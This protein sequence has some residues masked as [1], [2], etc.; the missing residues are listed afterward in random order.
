[1]GNYTSPTTYILISIVGQSNSSHIGLSTWN[2]LIIVETVVRCM[3][4]IDAAAI[5]VN[6]RSSQGVKG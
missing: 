4:K 3:C 6:V 5:S 2:D 1:M